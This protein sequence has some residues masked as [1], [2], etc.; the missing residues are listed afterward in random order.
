MIAVEVESALYHHH[1][2]GER[3]VGTD[4]TRQQWTVSWH[5]FLKSRK[6]RL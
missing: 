5:L 3:P 1:P 2:V 6:A 4:E